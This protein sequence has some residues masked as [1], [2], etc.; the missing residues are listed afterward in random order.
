MTDDETDFDSV[1][2][3]EQEVR[4]ELV[5]SSLEDFVTRY[6][7]QV[8]RR[9]LSRS[10]AMWCPAWWA[11]EEAVARL[12]VLWRA[13]EHLKEDEALGLSFWWTQHADPHLSALMDPDHGPFALCDARDGHAEH[14]L[15]PLPLTPSPPGMW[16]DPVFIVDFSPKDGVSTSL[17]GSPGARS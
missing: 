3:E 2:D 14:P 4:S 12:S 13:F 7:A 16:D 17:P 6:I 5:F 8:V 1:D 11:H 15:G 9:R 10:V